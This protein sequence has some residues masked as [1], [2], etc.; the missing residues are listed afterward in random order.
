LFKPQINGEIV[1]NDKT[2]KL[3]KVI[4]E[5]QQSKYDAIAPARYVVC[6]PHGF[7]FGGK[8]IRTTN[9]AVK[10]LCA[11]CGIPTQFFIERMNERERC[12]VFNRLNIQHAEVER[13]Y[14]FQNDCLY[15][16]V[17]ERYKKI[18]NIRILDILQAASDS[19]IGLKPVKW[20]LNHD[21]TRV[22]LVPENANVGELTP[23]ITVTNSENGLASLSL[24]AG[25]YRWV[26]SNGMMV[27][28]SDIAKSR[29]MHIGKNDISLPDIRIVL[30]KSFEWTEKLYDSKSRYLSTKNK[31]DIVLDITRA[32]GQKAAEK[33]IETANK[34]YHGGRTMFDAVGAITQAAHAFRPAVQTE[35]EHYA[36][37]LLK[38]A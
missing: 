24:W 1:M 3:V 6:S 31:S 29:W 10:Q 38:V 33:M 19:G 25:V 28:V 30:N 21:H 16:V 20:T 35:L 17:S 2:E 5:R 34:S 18:D 32:L 12:A 36:A 8:H 11:T 9:T 26:C 14:R 22:V 27:P 4:T 7:L 13:L 37:T 15:G 23:S